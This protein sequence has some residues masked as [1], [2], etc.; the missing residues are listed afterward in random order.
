I[1]CGGG[2]NASW[3]IPFVSLMLDEGVDVTK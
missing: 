1:S 2:C 3:D